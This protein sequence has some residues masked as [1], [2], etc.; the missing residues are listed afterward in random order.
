[1]LPASFKPDLVLART[2]DVALLVHSGRAYENGFAFTFG[3]QTRKPR[4]GHA[5]NPMV[6]WHAA[7]HT[8]FDDQTVRFGIAFADGRKATIFDPHPWWGDPERSVTPEIVLMQRGGGGG[9]ASWDFAFW[10]WPLPPEGP[11][12]FVVEWPAQG[13]DLTR[14]ELDSAIVRDAA[15]HALT[16]WPE[17]GPGGTG[18]VWTRMRK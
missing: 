3:L 10:V 2:D 1:V 18:R 16:L 11:I 7:R 13:I 9:G 6:G 5:D 12:E 8:G 14:M 15:T 17:T 4:E